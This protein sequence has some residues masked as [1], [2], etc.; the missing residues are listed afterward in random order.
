MDH[1]A[2]Q[3]TRYQRGTLSRRQLLERGAALGLG[4]AALSALGA[5]NPVAGQERF[6]RPSIR[7]MAQEGEQLRAYLATA[8]KT[9][10]LGPTDSI[11]RG[12]E[13]GAKDF[14]YETKVVEVVQGEYTETLRSLASSGAELII[15]AYPPM[16]DAVVEIAPQYP[17]QN[18]A[19]IVG[20]TPDVIPNVMSFWERAGDAAYLVGALA[21]LYSTSGVVGA[22]FPT[23]N[24]EMDRFISGYQ[25]GAKATNK[26]I[27]FLLNI[28][29]G[30]NPFE[31]PATAK[32]LALVHH[33]QGADVVFA[34][35]GSTCL[36][37]LE[38]AAESNGGFVSTGADPDQCLLH[39]DSM[40]ATVRIYW[41]NMTYRAMKLNREGAWEAGNFLNGIVEGGDDICTFDDSTPEGHLDPVTG[42]AIG[43]KLPQEVR[44]LIWNMRKQIMAG[45]IEISETVEE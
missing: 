39:P 20:S 38:A 10:D 22:T 36:G 13:R 33:E 32:R 18:F 40:L 9:G 4:A 23:R 29:G 37:V 42:H 27:K 24:P 11:V 3:I 35:G 6:V 34:A 5:I 17:D 7:A 25:Q 45:E 31:D 2:E 30:E 43:P 28:V 19:L 21:G 16:I 41:D 14:N 26:D 8:Q 1:L 44:E 15:A 12:L